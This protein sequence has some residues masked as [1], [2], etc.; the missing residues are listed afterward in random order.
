MDSM[1]SAK[2]GFPRPV[3]QTERDK[4]RC[5]PRFAT[6]AN[7][8]AENEKRA[9]GKGTNS[10]KRE[11]RTRSA[12]AWIAKLILR[13]QRPGASTSVESR[14][15][16]LVANSSETLDSEVCRLSLVEILSSRTHSDPALGSSELSLSLLHSS[17]SSFFFF[18]PSFFCPSPGLDVCSFVSKHRRFFRRQAQTSSASPD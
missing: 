10:G 17:L 16:S 5:R 15:L 7:E 2:R 13:Y 3:I 12:R 4:V 11:R 9:R 6:A 1:R 18:F 14:G 8:G